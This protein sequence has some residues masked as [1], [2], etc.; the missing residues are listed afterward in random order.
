M[1]DLPKRGFAAMTPEQRSAIARKGGQA[2]PAAKRSFSTNP[3]LAAEAGRKGGLAVPPEKRTFAHNRAL[4]VEAG[5]RGG[6][7]L[8]KKFHEHD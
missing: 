5:S 8:A 4:A 7:A 2:V 3:S 1:T 6:K